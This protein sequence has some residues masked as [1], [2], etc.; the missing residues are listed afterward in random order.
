M[1]NEP[2]PT[3]AAQIAA[4]EA[5]SAAASALHKIASSIHA[6][7]TRHSATWSRLTGPLRAGVVERCMTD[8]QIETLALDT[9]ETCVLASQALGDPTVTIFEC[10][11][12]DITP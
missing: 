2:Q 6:H 3:P 11:K 12:D 8:D 7:K 1:S 9:F 4:L 5:L 10:G